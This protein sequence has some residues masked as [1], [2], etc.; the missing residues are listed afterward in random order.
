[1]AFFSL[2]D[3]TGCINSGETS[4]IYGQQ[5]NELAIETYYKKD[6]ITNSVLSH[7]GV[8]CVFGV[9]SEAFKFL[10]IVDRDAFYVSL[11]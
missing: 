3:I 6:Y 5:F 11:P 1:M 7:Y 9:K 10:N 2:S 4:I 8:V